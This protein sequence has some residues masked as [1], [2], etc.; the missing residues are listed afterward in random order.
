MDELIARNDLLTNAGRLRDAADEDGL[1]F[2]RGFLDAEQ[3]LS[4]RNDIL[5]LCD[6]AGWLA[7]ESQPVDG[8]AAPGITHVEPQPE[9]MRVYNRVMRLESF[10]DLAHAPELLSVLDALFGEPT[11]VHARNIARIIFPQNVVYTTPAHQDFVHVQ[12][13]ENT[14]TAWIPLGDCPRE[15]GALALMRGSHRNGVFPA[16]SA[17]GAGGL[18]IDTEQLPYPWQ[19][20]DFRC[21]DVVL[22]HSLLVHKGLPNLSDDRLRLSVDYRYQGVS[23]PATEASFLPHY[24]QVSWEEVYAGWKSKT[25]QYYWL[26]QDVRYADFT[27]KYHNAARVGSSDPKGVADA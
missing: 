6:E 18:G 10:H 17:Y 25:R 16:R 11:L 15:L 14:W 27:P 23:Q 22:F 21:G 19:T 7:P 24:A 2:F 9:F 13:T 3:I 20:A 8:R 26:K 4:V 5:G 12:G 1:L